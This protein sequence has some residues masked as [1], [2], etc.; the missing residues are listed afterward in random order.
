M[1]AR[2][3]QAPELAA[4]EVELARKYSQQKIQSGSLLPSGATA[5]FGKK[6]SVV[7]FCQDCAAERRIATSDPFQVSRCPSCASSAK[8]AAKK[9]TKQERTRQYSLTA[10]WRHPDEGSDYWFCILTNSEVAV[11]RDAIGWLR[12]HAGRKNGDSLPRWTIKP[13]AFQAE[14]PLVG[15]DAALAVLIEVSRYGRAEYGTTCP[16]FEAHF[17]VRTEAT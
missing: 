14:A 8:R 11:V 5:E 12:D 7:I 1:P 16:V 15:Q 6:R 10:A 13:T 4:I 3:A 9:A 17:Q 2:P